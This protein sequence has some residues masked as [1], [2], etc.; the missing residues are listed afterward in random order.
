MNY[1]SN[2]ARE[3]TNINPFLS[4][5]Q[6]LQYFTRNVGKATQE[7]IHQIINN[8]RNGN[9]NSDN[10]LDLRKSIDHFLN[11]QKK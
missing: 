2:A 6:K 11:I 1:S 7:Q 3:S 10:I 9:L 8:L 5:S 4:Y